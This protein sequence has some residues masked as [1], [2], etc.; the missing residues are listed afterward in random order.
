[1]LDTLPPVTTG[2]LEARGVRQAFPKAAGGELVV[3]DDVTLALREGEIVGLLG[4]SGCGKST[5]LRI[6]AGLIRPSA[7][8]CAT[9]ASPCGAP[10]RASRWC[11]RPLRSS[12]G[13]PCSRTPRS[14]S[15]RAAC[16]KRKR[17]AA[18]SR[19]STSSGST[20]TNSP[21]RA[22]FRA[23]CASASAL[24]ARSSSSPRSCSWTSRSRR[25]TCSPRRRCAPTFS[26][27]GSRSACR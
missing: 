6:I 20:G 10:P 7:A 24:R 22:S 3:L 9:R 12:L 18:R 27:S 11:S 19:R 5:L 2:V 17:A 8:R 14:G 1:M 4:R 25:S 23:A 21:T 15:R 16:R 13:S 26:T